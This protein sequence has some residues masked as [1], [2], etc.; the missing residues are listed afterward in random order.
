MAFPLIHASQRLR[1]WKKGGGGV[2]GEWGGILPLL[3]MTAI[4]KA[5]KQFHDKEERERLEGGPKC[6]PLALPNEH[7]GEICQH[8]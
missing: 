3:E 6:F 8:M 7:K 2:G 1:A 5:F 4:A